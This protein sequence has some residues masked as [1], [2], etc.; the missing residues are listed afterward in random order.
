MPATLSSAANGAIKY[1]IENTPTFL[2]ESRGVLVFIIFSLAEL[3]VYRSIALGSA[4]KRVFS[5]QGWCQAHSKEQTQPPSGR[6][7]HTQKVF[8]TS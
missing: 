3:E 8:T 1:A 5:Q 2:L 7:R 4:R 6:R